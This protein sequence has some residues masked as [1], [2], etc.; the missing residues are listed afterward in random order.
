MD[1]LISKDGDLHFSEGMML[2]YMYPMGDC[3]RLEW[4]KPENKKQ[5]LEW[6]GKLASALYDYRE[7][8]MRTGFEIELPDSTVFKPDEH[9][10]DYAPPTTEGWL[11]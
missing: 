9:L 2:L 4:P 11:Y 7:M 1:K 6:Q 5:L 10:G 8:G 3:D